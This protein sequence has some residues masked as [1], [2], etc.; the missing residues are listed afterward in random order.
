MAAG[1]AYLSNS[2]LVQHFGLGAA[3]RADVV[4]IDW[5]SGGHTRLQDVEAD[6]LYDIVEGVETALA[7]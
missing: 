4:E 7:R 6:H 1:S 2:S 3:V 5:P